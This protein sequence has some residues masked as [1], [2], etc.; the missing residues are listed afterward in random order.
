MTS[1]L[2]M[3]IR[4][5]FYSEAARPGGRHTLV[6]VASWRRTLNLLSTLITLPTIPWFTPPRMDSIFH[7]YLEVCSIVSN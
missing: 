7:L 6:G 2:P 3:M 4:F 1:P 5:P